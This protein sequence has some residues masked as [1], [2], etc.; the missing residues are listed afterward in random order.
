MECLLRIKNVSKADELNQRIDGFEL[1]F[2][3]TYNK[4]L[5]SFLETNPSSD[6]IDFLV[7]LRDNLIFPILLGIVKRRGETDTFMSL[8]G[9]G[10]KQYN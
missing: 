8:R 7:E 2:E 3:Y 5:K 6:Q 10:F 4:E 9:I 1:D